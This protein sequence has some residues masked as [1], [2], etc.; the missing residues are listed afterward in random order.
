MLSLLSACTVEEPPQSESQGI[1]MIDVP[2]GNESLSSKLAD[3][4][5]GPVT[6]VS[7]GD[8]VS[9]FSFPQMVRTGEDLVLAWTSQVSGSNQVM[10]A[11]VPIDTL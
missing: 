3:G 2:A 7:G 11:R 8:N 6:I 9:A 10:S 4:Q 5:F 1:D